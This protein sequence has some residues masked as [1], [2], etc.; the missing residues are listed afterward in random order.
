MD[1]NFAQIMSHVINQPLL[2]HPR[3]GAVFYNVLA[4]RGL[5][6]TI[7]L[8]DIDADAIDALRAREVAERRDAIEAAGFKLMPQASRFV[9][10]RPQSDAGGYEPF[11]LTRDGIGIITITGTMVSRGAWIGSYS[12]QT[13]YEGVQA[14]LARAGS[15]DRVKALVLD[16]ETPGGQAMRAFETA[17]AVRAVT[18][19]KPVMA[20]VNGM[21]ASAGYA[22]ASAATK[23]VSIPSGFSGSVGVLLMHLDYSQNLA[24]DGIRPTLIFTPAH[25][26]DGNSLEPLTADVKS[27]LQAEVQALYEGFIETIERG[28][29]KRGANAA[30]DTE[31]RALMGQAA[32]DAKLIDE[33]G[34]FESVLHDLG[35]KPARS[36]ASA[37]QPSKGASRMA[38]DTDDTVTR[39]E[40][41]RLV[42]DADLAGYAR[43]RAEAHARFRAILAHEKVKGHEAFALKLAAKSPDMSLEDL[44]ETIAELPTPAAATNIASI[45]DRAAKTGADRVSGL[46]TA[47]EQNAGRGN[48][49]LMKSIAEERAEAR[50]A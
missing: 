33:L 5:G 6:S 50:R 12:G 18:K 21:A 15:D 14:Q 30:R 27:E 7:T 42:R 23:I 46:P 49:G 47:D 4:A 25:K 22:M 26:A 31:G 28:R 41:N 45:A 35:K 1:L 24:Q 2:V 8:P 16:M 9:G 44:V 40:S 13:S 19:R 34:T 3:K 32:V 39:A 37:G 11:M 17:D 29:G 36:R 38:D 43:G 48:K 20:V 10:E